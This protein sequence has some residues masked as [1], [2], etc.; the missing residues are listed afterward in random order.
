MELKL[1]V[2][3][4]KEVIKTYTAD[5][6]D[7]S[8]GVVEDVLNTLDFENMNTNAQIG[9]QVIKASKSL[10]PFLKDIFEGLT[11]EELRTVKMS[12]IVEIFKGLYNY[13]ANELGMIPRK[14]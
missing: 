12:N 8:F 1:R 3:K 11:E 6:I 9:L 13:A 7:C 14:N 4:G 5:T 10:S 2:Y